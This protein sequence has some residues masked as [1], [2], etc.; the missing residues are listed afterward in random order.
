VRELANIRGQV[1]DDLI[2]DESRERWPA[3]GL[4][5]LEPDRVLWAYDGSLCL[6]A[7]NPMGA[8]CGYVGVDVSHPWYD[9]KYS[10][11]T[12]SYDDSPE[13]RVDVHG[14]VTFSGHCGGSLILCCDRCFDGEP[15][16]ELWFF[17]FD[18]GHLGDVIP[19]MLAGR[20]VPFDDNDSYRDV[21][22]VI[23][24]VESLAR[25]LQQ[26]QGEIDVQRVG[27]KSK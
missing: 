4:W 5:W 1:S 8:L 3:T 17:G 6:I 10:G 15:C 13:A 16:R 25:Q 24:Q 7:R 19:G 22:Y 9:V 20:V 12:D 14:G 11:N 26:Q 21:G 27:S 23:D 2:S 18:C